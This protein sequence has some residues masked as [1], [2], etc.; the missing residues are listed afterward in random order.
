M[1]GFTLGPDRTSGSH[2]ASVIQIEK[3]ALTMQR[4]LANFS[5]VTLEHCRMHAVRRVVAV[6]E[7]FDVDNHLLAH[8]DT[9]FQRG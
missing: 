5:I 3:F 8:V 9:A 6:E 2:L 4:V 1:L 7:G